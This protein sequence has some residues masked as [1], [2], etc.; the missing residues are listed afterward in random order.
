MVVAG[1]DAGRSILDA[2]PQEPAEPTVV[3][4]AGDA[5]AAAAGRMGRALPEVDL[6][7]MLAN[8]LEASRWD[9]VANRCLAC[10]NCTMACPTCFCTS[11]SETTDLTG[12]HT[13][14]WQQWVSCFEAD[15]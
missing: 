10:G 3:A 5:V 1:S 14:R 2:L 15:F 8:T 4:A 13:E 6:R 11:V 12:D 9:E 7:A